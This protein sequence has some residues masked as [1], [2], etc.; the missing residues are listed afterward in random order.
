LQRL[1]RDAEAAL[2]RNGITARCGSDPDH[3]R[4]CFLPSGEPV[5]GAQLGPVLSLPDGPGD[6]DVKPLS[7]SDA[8]AWL[9]AHPSQRPGADGG[10]LPPPEMEC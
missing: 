6:Y 8:R 2:A 3:P 5:P 4:A 1:N 10:E 7:S 9:C